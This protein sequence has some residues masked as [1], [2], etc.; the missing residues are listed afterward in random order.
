LS[1]I[2]K[3][4][5]FHQ[6]RMALMRRSA[7]VA[8]LRMLLLATPLHASLIAPSVQ[9]RGAPAHSA[10][11]TPRR[12]AGSL[13]MRAIGVDS[14]A[15]LD[16][17]DSLDEDA[18]VLLTGDPAADAMIRLKMGVPVPKKSQ[19]VA[20]KPRREDMVEAKGHRVGERMSGGRRASEVATGLNTREWKAEVDAVRSSSVT[21][22]RVRHML[23]QTEEL[24]EMLLGQLQEG[25][26]FE[27]RKLPADA[28]PNSDP[29]PSPHRRHPRHHHHRRHRRHRRRHSLHHR[30]TTATTARALPLTLTPTRSSPRSRRPAPPPR[31]AGTSDGRGSRTST[32]TRHCRAR[33]A[34]SLSR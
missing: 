29:G 2:F 19:L 13:C 4:S 25:A 31:R 20:K 12:G 32:S 24:A 33:R 26:K 3:L 34:P 27:V 6:L 30:H 8:A 18:G 21:A 16:G 23:V 17:L 7:S 1:E 9:L 5:D 11:A 14:E 10:A 15:S 28:N 22:V